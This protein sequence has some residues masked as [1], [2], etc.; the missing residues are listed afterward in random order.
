MTRRIGRATCRNLYDGGGILLRAV[1][2]ETS[3][4]QLPHSHPHIS[5]TLIMSGAVKEVSENGATTG[6]P[7][8]VVVKPAGLCHSDAYGQGG[9]RSFQVNIASDAVH[10]VSD[11][12]RSLRYGWYHGGSATRCMLSLVQDVKMESTADGTIVRRRLRDVL[13]TLREPGPLIKAHDDA[14][15]AFAN[16]LVAN[17]LDVPAVH[18]VAQRLGM[19]PV[20]LARAFRRRFGCSIT[21]YRR[22]HRVLGAC[23]DVAAGKSSLADIAYAAGFADQPHFCRAFKTELG[24]S[25]GEYRRMIA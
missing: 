14:L 17:P 16:A 25:P 9:V 11:Y 2:Y 12:A 5:I 20:S 6:A 22:R 10:A 7:C 8:S 15:A 3:A 19:H 18:A 24:V 13:G 21:E 4:G 23:A 1:D